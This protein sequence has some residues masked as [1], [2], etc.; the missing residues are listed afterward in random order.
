MSSSTGL[1]KYNTLA[2]RP[3]SFGGATGGTSSG[4]GVPAQSSLPIVFVLRSAVPPESHVC[5]HSRCTQLVHLAAPE[6]LNSRAAGL[7]DPLR[8]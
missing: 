4:H 2:T 7:T 5:L 3:A 6:Q 1:D 8:G